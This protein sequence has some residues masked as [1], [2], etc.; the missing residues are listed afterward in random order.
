MK[1]CDIG[2]EEELLKSLIVKHEVECE[3]DDDGGEEEYREKEVSC[4]KEE[5]EDEEKK[6]RKGVSKLLH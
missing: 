2:E 4:E 1:I 5:E 3:D 6:D